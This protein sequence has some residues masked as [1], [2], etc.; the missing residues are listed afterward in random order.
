MKTSITLGDVRAAHAR[1]A[2]GIMR[3]PC[4]ESEPL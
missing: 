4:P 1:I 3:T 2:S